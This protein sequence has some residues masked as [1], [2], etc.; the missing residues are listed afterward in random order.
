MPSTQLDSASFTSI[1]WD[2]E[3]SSR[4][5]VR[6]RTA[7]LV[8]ALLAVAALF[9]YDYV[10]VPTELVATLDWDV[11]RMDWLFL[12][13][14]VLF[15]RYAVVPLVTARDRSL[16]Y[17]REF[18][19]RP[20]GVFSFAYIAGFA[21]LGLVG[22]EWFG[23][24]RTD[25][26]AAVQP[27]V[28]TSV[29]TGN[30]VNDVCVGATTGDYCH[31][32]WA[33]PLGTTRLGEGV[34]KIV[35]KGMRMALKLS[36][37]TVT[38]MVVIATTVGTTAGYYGGLVDDL[39][40]RYVDVQQTIPAIVVYIVLSTMYLGQGLFALALVF[41]LLN[42]G[43]IAR[44]VRSEVLQRRSEGFVRAAQAAGASNAHVIRKHLI[45]NSAATIVTA[46]TRQIPLLILA[47]VALAYLRLNIVG[48]RSLGGVLRR[49]LSY[50]P[51][52]WHVKWW[53]TLFPALF[54]LLTVVSF[55]VFGDVVRDVLDPKGEVA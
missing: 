2:E 49:G 24:A 14:S 15:V 16:T 31:G 38:I 10:A 36:V 12:V 44:L 11:T 5:A 33:Y 35:V 25:L 19:R 17:L 4:W 32:T 53:V 28:F 13:S 21:V 39:L 42:W 48:L 45:P 1:D 54:L 40:M 46:L 52:A 26:Y 37:G 41:G 9:V 29:Y 22:P 55:N 30:I 7:G 8:V 20:A 43:G 51:V 34:A 27:P 50:D 47:Q 18:A 6:K 23:L 3:S